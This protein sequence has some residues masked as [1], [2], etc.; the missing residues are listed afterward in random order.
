MVKH[1]TNADVSNVSSIDKTRGIYLFYGN[2]ELLYLGKAGDLRT[3]I[4]QHLHGKA[5]TTDICKYFEQVAVIYIDDKVSRD[6][7]ETMLINLWKPKLNVD[8]A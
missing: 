8:K 2:N 3:R 6:I 5:N 4:V 1:V 7:M